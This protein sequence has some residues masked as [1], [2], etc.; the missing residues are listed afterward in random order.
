MKSFIITCIVAV[1]ISQSVTAQNILSKPVSM[2]P[3]QEIAYSGSEEKSVS[4]A[5]LYSLLLPG[6]GELYAGNYTTGK[7]FTIVEGA[8]WVT[9]LSFDRYGQ[10]LQDDARNY[11]VQH[12]GVVLAGKDDQYFVNIGDYQT[13]QDY[14]DARLRARDAYGLYDVKSEGWNWDSKANRIFYSDQR[15]SSDQAFSNTSFVGAAIAVNHLVSAINAALMV[16]SRNAEVGSVLPVDIHASVMGG[17]MN[18][19]G[20]RISLSKK[21]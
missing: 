8:L 4:L 10:W 14:N 5:V 17:M 15:I 11:A 12:A 18:P 1:L 3:K 6:M 13:V 2:Y 7:Y 20:I 9:L 21:F 19:H 16:K